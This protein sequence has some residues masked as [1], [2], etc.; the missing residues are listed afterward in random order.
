MF[1]CK[2]KYFKLSPGKKKLIET[3]TLVNSWSCINKL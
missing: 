3:H 1:D 2:K